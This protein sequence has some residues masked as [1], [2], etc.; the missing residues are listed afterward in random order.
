MK[1]TAKPWVSG[2][3]NPSLPVTAEYNPHERCPGSVDGVECACPHHHEEHLMH[4]QER[5]DVS[6]EQPG[7]TYAPPPLS[8]DQAADY[9]MPT[10]S[11]GLVS[12]AVDVLNRHLVGYDPSDWR[13]AVRL[14]HEIRRPLALLRIIDSTLSTWIYLHGEHGLHQ[15]IDGVPGPIDVTRGR[16][17]E[18]WAFAELAQ[19]YV[20]TKIEAAGGELVDPDQIVAWVLEVISPGRGRVGV[21]QDAGLDVA[22]YRT[23]EPGTIQIGLP[24]HQLT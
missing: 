23:S 6:T 10:H 1:A 15:T 8:A 7:P 24:Q 13:D 20:G 17:R 16:A 5:A 9:D 18:R 14:L 12:V 11:A 4:Q 22:D 2:Y 19:D 3:C 21:T